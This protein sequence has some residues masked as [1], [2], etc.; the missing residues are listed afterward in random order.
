[1]SEALKFFES[2]ID[3]SIAGIQTCLPCQIITFYGSSADVQPILQRKLKDGRVMR[4]P[5]LIKVP[6]L[7]R[8]FKQGVDIVIEDP[9]YEKG[10]TVLVS[11]TSRDLS[12]GTIIGLL[13]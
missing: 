10:D 4:Y 5:M 7:K 12:E 2:M 3:E 6:V 9:F 8:K 11:F 13:G 1:M